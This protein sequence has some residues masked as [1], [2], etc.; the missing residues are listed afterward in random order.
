M[1]SQRKIRPHWHHLIIFI[2]PALIIYTIFMAW[3]LIDSLRISFFASTS[4]GSSFVGLENYAHILSRNDGAIKI[5]LMNTLKFLGIIMF[6]GNPIALFLASL[7][8]ST[9]LRWKYF[10]QTTLFIPTVM[11]VVIA[12]WVWTLM[13]NPLWGIVNTAFT[14]VGLDSLIPSTGWLGTSGIALLIIALV[15]T[16]QFIG[17]PM[18]LFLAALVNIDEELLEA[19]MVDGASTLELFWKIKFPLILPEVGQVVILTIILNFPAFDIQQ[20][21]GGRDATLMA[22]VFYYAYGRNPTDATVIGGIMFAI[23]G[24]ASLIYFLIFQRRL[25]RT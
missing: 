10:Y 7:L 23:V 18:V 8:A 6:V 21:M 16:W 9:N 15:A 11:S 4:D 3:P 20:V 13:L 1:N 24:G 12:G 5:I 22:N 25:V 2:A 14:T 19:A 17:L